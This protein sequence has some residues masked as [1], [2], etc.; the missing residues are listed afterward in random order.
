MSGRLLGGYRLDA[1]LGAGGMGEVYRSHDAK[2]GR[3]VAIKILPPAFTSH[4]DRLARFEREARM[5]AALNHPRICA[6]YG[7]EEAAGVR[8][9]ILELVE[10]S[11]LAQRLASATTLREKSVGLPLAEVVA[12]ARQIAEALEAAHEK[13]IIHRDLKPANIKITPDG[14]VKVLD[15][16]LAKTVG[17]DSRSADLSSVPLPDGVRGEGPLIGTAAYMSPEQARGTAVDKR[18]DIW[19]FGCVLYE[20]LTGRV[21]FSGDT[22]SD[23]IA[24]ILEREPDWSA[25]P[26]ATPPPIRRL[27]LRCLTK[28]P[29][30][31]LRD[32]GDARIEIDRIAEVLP[33]SDAVVTAPPARGRIWLALPWLI[34]ASLAAAVVSWELLR[35]VSMENPL[36]SEGF[37][38]LTNWPGSESYAEISPDG[39][40]VAFLAD[41]DGE[42]DLF[43]GLVATGDFRNVTGNIEP[44]VNPVGVLRW[45]GFFPDSA[46]L[47]FSIVARQKVEMPWSGGSPRPFLTDGDHTP[48]WSTDDRLIY[49]NNADGDHLWIADA[50]GRNARKLPIDWPTPPVTAA[51]EAYHNHNMVWSPDNK[52]IY[53]VR[54]V[55]R[56]LNRQTFEM[57]IWR[58]PPSGG[59]PERLTHLN[60]PLTFLAML[61]A[62]TLVFVGPDENGFGSWLWSLEVGRLRTS[63]RW[64]GAERVLPKRIPTGSQQY[65]SISASRNRG[66]L[67]ATQSNSTASLWSVPIRIDRP[68]TESDVVPLQ[69]QTGRA[70]APRYARH[71]AAPLLFFL[72]GR[73]TGDRVW[74]FATTGVE[75]T[76]G[77]EGHLIETPAPAPDGSRV[78]VVVKESGRRRL[79]VMNQDGQASQLLA[80]SVEIIGTADWSPDGRWIAAGGRDAD[81]LGLFAIPLDGGAPRRLVSSIATDPVWS[82]NGDFI[83]YTGPFSGAT[84]TA[85]AAGAPL[86]AV[87]LDG[88]KYDL[89]RVPGTGG[90]SE[91]LRVSPEGY[92]F[93]SQTRLVYRP[94]PEAL[95][96]WLFDLVTGAQRQITRLSNKGNVRG[97]DVTPDGTQLVFD[98][99]RQNSDIVLIDLPRK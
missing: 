14:T 81:G 59:L 10:G 80:S 26:A 89:A 41:R 82:P 11:T 5:L 23:S 32:I 77:A 98:R 53:F 56:D 22:I 62:D 92:R 20:M 18:T 70:L 21:T 4:P 61:D 28:D 86:K 30:H 44:L 55:V 66:P 19:A 36:P 39:K 60:A 40:A 49:F 17:G 38:P 46:R 47:W 64:W 24:K 79:A 85:R 52:W 90:L 15:F 6:I 8:F 25:L 96:F 37:K 67:V 71:T 87:R 93:L 34:L 50:A 83:V 9:L 75:I 73:G 94:R 63:G 2:L 7:F 78:A 51:Y 97:F 58:V 3:D 29:K 69:V 42:L 45:T 16:G 91:D 35:P 13:G 12:V 84:A 1:S 33:G 88:T 54:G 57:D 43:S 76:K 72:S 95:D 65:T 48:A 99:I 74:R 31:R 27:L 68:A